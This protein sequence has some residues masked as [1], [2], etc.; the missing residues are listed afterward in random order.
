MPFDRRKNLLLFTV[1]CSA[2]FA[3]GSS[4]ANET[5]S[6][7]V[8]VDRSLIKSFVQKMRDNYTRADLFLQDAGMQKKPLN[9]RGLSDGDNLIFVF[10]LPT[11]DTLEG[12]A[13]AEVYNDTIYLSMR[14]ILNVLDFPI[15]YDA[16][17]QNFEG[18]F[19]RE[20]KKFFLDKAA[21]IVRSDGQEYAIGSN[22]LVKDDDLY[23]PY[24]SYESWFGLE[25][26]PDIGLQS[27]KLDAQPPLP[28]MERIARRNYKSRR[29]YSRKPA[30]LP[31]G[32]DDYELIG[33]PLV[34]VYTRSSYRN[35]EGGDIQRRQDVNV[36]TSG[37]FNSG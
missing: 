17:T 2:V 18:W 22:I 21:G 16:Q 8:A 20:N 13:L 4:R 24:S 19:V 3:A 7:P 15:E 12:E 10:K 30:T 31:R 36:R 26:K 1:C 14:D 28:V 35:P 9:L 6:E 25:L 29:D 5:Q 32:D 27:V 33:V 37:E 23:F 11:N 34:D